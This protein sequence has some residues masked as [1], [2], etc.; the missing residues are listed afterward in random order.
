MGKYAQNTTVSVEKSQFE[1][2]RILRKYGAD[3]FG[4]MEDKDS[5][6]LMFQY[7]DLMIQITVPLPQIDEFKFTEAGR[8]RTNKKAEESHSQAIRQ[9]W[10]ALVLAV[11]AKLEAVESGIST[12]EKEFMAFVVMPDGKQL[13]DH[14]LPELQ[15]MAK[16]GK[17]PKL[18]G[19]N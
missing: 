5:A 10:R 15:S 11:K 12:L 19:I 9:R 1:V 18:L 6:Y 4:T 13:G 17:M 3:K 7:N 8:K 2:Q 14:L 16:T